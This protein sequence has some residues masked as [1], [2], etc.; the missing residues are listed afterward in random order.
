MHAAQIVIEEPPGQAHCLACGRT[1]SIDRHG[2]SRPVCA[3]HWLHPT[4]GMELRVIDM[5]VR[6]D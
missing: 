5:K 2:D 1:V 4:G 3:S 6:D